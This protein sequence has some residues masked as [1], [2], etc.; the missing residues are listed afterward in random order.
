[1]LIYAAPAIIWMIMSLMR[2]IILTW[3]NAFNAWMCVITTVTMS[4]IVF[5][6]FLR[7]AFMQ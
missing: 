6:F 7:M 4:M 2:K 1:M 3:P 5:E